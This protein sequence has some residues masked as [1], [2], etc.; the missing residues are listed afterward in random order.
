M[1]FGHYHQENPLVL[2]TRSLYF[3]IILIAVLLSFVTNFGFSSLLEPFLFLKNNGSSFYPSFENTFLVSMEWWRLIT[4]T[5]LHFSLTHL[6]FNCLWI[7]ILGSK[8]EIVDGK[9]IFL[10][11]FLFVG[12]SSNLGQYFLTGDYL[13]G[14]LSGAVYGLLGYCFI[15]DLD[16]RG[17]RYDLPNALYIFM[18]IWLLIGFTGVLKVFGFG[19]VANI[20]HLVGMIAGFFL[21]IIAKYTLKI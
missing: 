13:F 8:I 7:Y 5:F 14:G 1:E 19:N 9:G 17:Q 12:L 10:T 15:L 11:L 3:Y 6:I 18:F 21:G 20:A 4:P 16:N 2:N